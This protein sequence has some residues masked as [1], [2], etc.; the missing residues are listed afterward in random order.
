VIAVSILLV[1]LFILYLG[2]A[3]PVP[4][5]GAGVTTGGQEDIAAARQAIMDGEIPDPDAITVEGFLSEHSIE[6]EP[7]ADPGLLY[8][9]ATTAWNSDFDAFTP[10]A[11]LQIGFGTTI[12]REDIQ[13]PDLNLCLVID[14]SG[15]MSDLVDERSETSK[16]DAVLIAIDRLLAR[17]TGDDLVS[18]V[19]F[20]SQASRLVRGAAGNDLAAIKGALEDLTPGGGTDLA[21][22][23]RR[24]F[25]TVEDLSN[26]TR[27]DRVIV[28]TDALLR[29][30]AD[31]RVRAFLDTMETYAD[32]GIGATVFGI[33]SQF[34]HE[35]A[36][37]ISQIRGGNY[38]FLS[39]YDRIV[40]VFDD[41]FEY[42]VTPIAYDVSLNVNVPF[43][44][45]VTGIYGLPTEEQ[46]PHAL[47]L[48]IPTLFLSS[49]EG[50]G[51]V[52][53]RIR[54]GALV[55]FDNENILATVDMTYETPEGTVETIPQIAASLPAGLDPS[56]DPP[57]FQTP[58]TQ[59]GVLLLNTSL[60]LK[61][62]CEDAY[63]Q[64]GY[65]YHYGLDRERAA[66]RL[67]EFLPYFD[68]L[69]DGLDDKAS[70]NSRS[71]SQER[72][73]VSQLLANVEARGF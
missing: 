12:E 49:R 57:Y 45:D 70:E 38:F 21:N 63:T 19:V 15:S 68:E 72:F 26:G 24:G 28:F 22:G 54:P 33:G 32:Q 8:A 35:V 27:S 48:T 60:V 20:D 67:S 40:S 69:A 5:G 46:F 34:G 29:Y 16:L 65:Y 1:P 52:L 51:A 10:L 23:L 25:N 17:L 55:D 31:A 62:A 7:P 6:V 42:L 61:T 41:E 66:Q 14:R 13:R 11:T 3:M 43:E 47:E 37:E 30:L 71:L 73:L 4:P 2:C 18:V 44:F 50:G 36:Y 53:I 59:R 9:V 39:D 64:Y 58:G 56:A